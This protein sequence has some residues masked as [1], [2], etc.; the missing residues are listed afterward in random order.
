MDEH[1]CTSS[2]KE[3]PSKKYNDCSLTFVHVAL[4][5]LQI[6]L[7]QNEISLPDYHGQTDHDNNTILTSIELFLNP[8][9]TS[10]HTHRLQCNIVTECLILKVKHDSK[11]KMGNNQIWLH[12]YLININFCRT[13]PAGSNNKNIFESDKVVCG[14]CVLVLTALLHIIPAPV[15]RWNN[16]LLYDSTVENTAKSMYGLPKQSTAMT[17][18]TVCKVRFSTTSSVVDKK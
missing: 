13:A 12:R 11:K 2:G 3:S 16:V 7:S 14:G 18:Q 10:A 5:G 9:R 15:H 17:Q 8:G 6:E 1:F 4:L